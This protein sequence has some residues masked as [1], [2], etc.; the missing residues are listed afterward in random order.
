MGPMQFI[1]QTWRLYGVDANN[2]VRISP[3]NFNDAA[4]SAAGYLCFR[5]VNLAT[6]KGWMTA[7]LAYNHSV[8]YA[9]TVR[10]WATAYAAGRSQ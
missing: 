9:R 1:P 6:A 3:D 7:M 5:G 4:L 10:D 8:L 2:E